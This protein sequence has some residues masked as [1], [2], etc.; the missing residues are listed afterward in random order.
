MP[1]F[2]CTLKQ[3]VEGYTPLWSTRI[4][5]RHSLQFYIPHLSAAEANLAAGQLQNVQ[6]F[7]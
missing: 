7:N 6:Q 3:R 2:I 5:Q 1:L 4:F